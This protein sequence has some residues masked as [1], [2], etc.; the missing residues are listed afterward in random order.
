MHATSGERRDWEPEV[1]GDVLA[2]LASRQSRSQAWMA[3]ALVT[4]I[5][6]LPALLSLGDPSVGDSVML[7]ALG[8]AAG[9]LF[10]LVNLFLMGMRGQTFGMI[11][12]GIRVVRASDSGH[13]GFLRAV[14]VRVW[15]TGSLLA[16]S[17]F[18][19]PWYEIAFVLADLAC[20]TGPSRRCLH[21]Y[22]SGTKVVNVW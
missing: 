20:I 19:G 9:G 17:A 3:D 5:L 10:T 18:L 2:Y 16:F 1:E 13:A 15:G 6:L 21:D 12:M 7:L 4:A 8:G 22:L 11:M 14:V